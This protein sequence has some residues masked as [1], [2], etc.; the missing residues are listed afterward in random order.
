TALN[1][2]GDVVKVATLG[3]AG[4]LNVG[5]GII[6][7]DSTLQL[8]SVGFS[9]EVRFIA[10]VSLSGN[11]TKHIA[12]NAVTINNGVVVTI[13]GPPANIY[14]NSTNNVPN[15]NYTGFG[16][17]N[18]PNTGTFQRGDNFDAPAAT[19]PQPFGNRPALDPVPGG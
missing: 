12:G 13:N 9:G 18:R 11:G 3:E 2:R 16:G 19:T 1:V 4:V 10:N 6:S 8:Y 7:A 17:N 14:V 5:G 15:A